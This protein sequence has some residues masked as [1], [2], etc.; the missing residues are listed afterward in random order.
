M[1]DFFEHKTGITVEST[2]NQWGN[3]LA[4]RLTKAIASLAGASEGDHVLVSAQPG[5]IV[6]E[7][8]KRTPSLEEMLA[9]FDPVK[10]GGEAM[11]FKPVGRE[12]L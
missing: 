2:V 10:H 7:L 8:E 9:S 6:I 1:G 5:R 11:A 4:V 3:G 12:V